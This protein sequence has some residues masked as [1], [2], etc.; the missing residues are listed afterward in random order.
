M[1]CYKTAQK[2]NLIDFLS[3]HSEEAFS[4][5]ELCEKMQRECPA[6]QLP[7]K[8]TV[9]RLIQKMTLDGTVKRLPEE[10]SRRFVYQIAAGESCA[11]HL[12][13]KCI[14]CGRLLHMDDDQSLRLLKEVF[15]Q[16]RFRVDER[17]T[18]LVGRCGDCKN[19]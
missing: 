1:A 3:K 16:N 4:V 2:K 13:M 6:S 10:N 17:Q 9:Y 14:K 18:V 19:V 12:H 5:E 15:D 11:S 7:G 8:S